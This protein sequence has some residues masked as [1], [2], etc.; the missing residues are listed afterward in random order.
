CGR[1]V[2]SDGG[3]LLFLQ[4]EVGIRDRPVIGVQTCTLPIWLRA[5]TDGDD[6]ERRLFLRRSSTRKGYTPKSVL[7][8]PGALYPD[9]REVPAITFVQYSCLKIKN[10]NKPFEQLSSKRR[11]RFDLEHGTAESIQAFEVLF[12][13]NCF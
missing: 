9:A 13:F 5:A 1:D 8:A 7:D 10:L 6:H 4:A 3:Y 2:R 12:A 11:A